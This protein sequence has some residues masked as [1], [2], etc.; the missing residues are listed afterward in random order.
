MKKM[1]L[2]LQLFDGESA[3]SSANSFTG[4]SISPD[5]AE[6]GRSNLSDV[7]YGKEEL[8]QEEEQ[9][10]A[11]D[12][13]PVEQGVFEDK[14]EKFEHLIKG[15]YKELFA[16]RIQKIIDERFK[17]T[18][19]L[20]SKIEKASPILQMLASKYGVKNPEDVDSIM[21]AIEDDDSYYEE[22]A[23]KSGMS[24]EQLKYIKSLE[25]QNEEFSRAKE[26]LERRENANRIYSKWMEQSEA[27]KQLYPAF[28]FRVETQNPTFT[29][30]LKSGIDVKTAYEVVH[31]DDIISGA[32]QYTARQ[33][34]KKVTDGIK[35]RS[36]RPIE[37]GTSAQ[38]A[39]TRKT[40]VN[41]LT[42]KD[43]EEIERRV[44]RG[45]RI[46]F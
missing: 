39:S 26:E 1:V 46:T 36:K 28:D 29:D 45:E 37:N 11:V 2:N 21:K 8:E 30:L 14:K 4:D 10:A 25:R 35:A 44:A 7:K 19:N 12:E 20:E 5:A 9:D 33:V 34:A 43:R 41:S 27:V 15:E 31:K 42:K 23:L 6:N 13:E 17:E 24:V 18:K 3:A 40:D 22:E 16:E 32:M 38:A